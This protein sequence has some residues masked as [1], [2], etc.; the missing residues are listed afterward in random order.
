MSW[1]A[2][3]ASPDFED[4]RNRIIAAM[5]HSEII[6]A[7]PLLELRTIATRLN[8]LLEFSQEDPDEPT[9]ALASLRE[10]ALF[11]ASEPQR[12]EPEIGLGPDGHLQGEWRV[13]DDGILVMKFLRDG[14]IQFAA[15]SRPTGDRLPFRVNGTLP[16]DGALDTVR[17]FVRRGTF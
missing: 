17:A 16:K 10:L 1:S 7:L 14:L 2:V 5:Q 11:F 8:Y 15:I 3:T 9:M 12:D 13:G 4:V 6:E